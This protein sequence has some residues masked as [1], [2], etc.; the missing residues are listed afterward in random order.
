MIFFD[1]TNTYNFWVEVNNLDG[2]FTEEEYFNNWKEEI[3]MV[4]DD[5]EMDKRLEFIS[6]YETFINGK[7]AL[8]V[9]LNEN[10]MWW[11]LED[12]YD[13]LNWLE[14][15]SAELDNYMEIYNDLDNFIEVVTL[16]E[17]EEI[18]EILLDANLSN[19][20]IKEIDEILNEGYLE[21]WIEFKVI[22]TFHN[23]NGISI[24]YEINE[25]KNGDVI[26]NDY[27]MDS[28]RFIY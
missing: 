20:L 17:L 22:F 21:K 8:V 9:V 13:E 18:K 26:I 15:T 16:E 7:K 19:W 23:G 4:K 25:E 3:E 28:L 5:S 27:M 11:K 24:G 6:E 10:E 2:E 1:E 14:G 12:I